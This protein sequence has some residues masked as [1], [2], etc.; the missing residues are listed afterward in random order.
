ML[1]KLYPL[2]DKLIKLYKSSDSNISSSDDLKKH[3]GF[4]IIKISSLN[5]KNECIGGIAALLYWK[6]KAEDK[7]FVSNIDF[8]KNHTRVDKHLGK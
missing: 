6:R 4:E 5:Y 3:N 8:F 1:Y 7:G 2:K